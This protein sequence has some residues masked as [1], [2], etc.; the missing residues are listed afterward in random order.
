[1]FARSFFAPRLVAT[2]VALGGLM[3]GDVAAWAAGKQVVYGYVT[4][5]P[6][7][8]Y[9][10]DV[11]DSPTLPSALGRR[12]SSSIPTIT[13]RRRSRTSTR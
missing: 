7:T 2:A 6:D 11:D 3:V 10:K 9:K 12:S 8:W 13:P 1:M 5:G 4:A